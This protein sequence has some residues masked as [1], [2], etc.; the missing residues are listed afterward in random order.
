MW[1]AA[2]APQAQKKEFVAR[3]AKKLHKP[4]NVWLATA[5]QAAPLLPLPHSQHPSTRPKVKWVRA[6]EPP[7]RKARP[8]LRSSSP[9]GPQRDM[10]SFHLAKNCRFII[11][12]KTEAKAPASKA[13]S[14]DNGLP[15]PSP[16]S[17]HYTGSSPLLYF[18]QQAKISQH[19]QLL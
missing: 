7:S 6:K 5:P 2:A 3:Q 10:L 11:Q 12:A 1:T 15:S 19:G 18:P 4:K 13:L 17:S 16:D 9:S 14:S 8:V